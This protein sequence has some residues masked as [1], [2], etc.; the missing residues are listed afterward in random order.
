VRDGED[1]AEISLAENI[2]RLP[3][4]PADQFAAFKA[5]ADD[6]KGAEEIA[7]RFGCA[8]STVRQRLRLASVSPALLDTYRADDMA[9][10]QLMAVRREVS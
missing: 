2:V 9:L 6:G 8:A 4:H 5:L 10:D 7:A 3:M 1:A